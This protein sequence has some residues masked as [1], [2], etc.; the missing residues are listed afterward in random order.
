MGGCNDESAEGRDL[1]T[2]R[3]GRILVTGA[4]GHLGIRLIRRRAE[5]GTSDGGKSKNLVVAQTV[6]I[7]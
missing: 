5:R 6:R 1:V 3:E 7:S 4:N 2:E